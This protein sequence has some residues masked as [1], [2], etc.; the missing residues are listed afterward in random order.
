[1]TQKI[2]PKETHI[3]LSG[4]ELD[5]LHRAM[6]TDPENVF[7]A[8]K[9]DDPHPWPSYLLLVGPYCRVSDPF[10]TSVCPIHGYN[11][12]FNNLHLA[13]NGDTGE[14]VM[15]EANLTQIG[16][17]KPPI[18]GNHLFAFIPRGIQ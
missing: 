12:S 14:I 16:G 3:Q 8:R 2:I 9:V 13:I 17:W 11:L 7:F 18:E 15:R 1:M 6:M 10:E 5:R 4:N